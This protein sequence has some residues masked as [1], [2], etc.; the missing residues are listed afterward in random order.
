[1]LSRVAE[2]M[3]WFG[4]YLE[5][6]ENSIRLVNVN[7]SLLLDLPAAVNKQIWNGLIEITGNTE[8]FYKSHTK[9]GEKSVTHFLLADTSNPGALICCMKMLRENIRTTRE[10]MPSETWEQINEFYLFTKNNL[11]KALSR[12]SRH[13]FLDDAMNFCHQIT[14][15]LSGNMSHG[16][17]YNFVRIGRNLERADMTSRI[18]DVGCMNLMT[19][20]GDI[21]KA[22]DNILWMNVLRSLSAYQMY[23]QN[24]LDK[25]NGEDVIDFLIK[26]V[27]FPRAIGH[28]LIEVNHCVSRLPK[29]DHALRS[30][31]RAQR[32]ISEMNAAKLIEDG[33]HEFIDEI[34][35]DLAGIHNHVSQT[36]FDYS[37]NA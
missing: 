3:Y 26:D 23:R 2:R 27:Q 15:L 36:W 24:V 35:I 5:R 17:A 37:S 1:M 30:I 19:Q 10:I 33:L 34:Q 29:N 28:C 4:R 31:T 11:Q 14:G 8:S 21:P 18:L 7:A 9:A 22:Y 25:V 32:N 6:A 20:K 16:E 12:G 13:E